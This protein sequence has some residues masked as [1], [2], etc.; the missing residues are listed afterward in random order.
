MIYFSRNTRL[1][2]IDINKP[3]DST[4]LKAYY[5]IRKSIF[6]D[7]QDLFQESDFDKHDHSAIPI[8]AINHYLGS[9]DEVVGVVRIYEENKREWFGGRLGVIKE[10]RSF[11]KF[12]CPNLFKERDVSAL[13]QMSIAA[14]LI[15]RAVSLA[16]YLGCDKFSA[17]VQEQNVKLFKRLHW[18]VIESINIYGIKHYLMEADLEAYPATPIYTVAPIKTNKTLTKLQGVA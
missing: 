16:N 13:Y 2:F 11:S 1:N 15:Y 6:C 9:P 18:K 5:N 10:Y 17:H 4:Q 7:E 14:G 12:I 3:S 8:I